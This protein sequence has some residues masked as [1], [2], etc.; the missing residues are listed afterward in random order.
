MKATKFL[1][2]IAAIT[3]AIVLLPC[4]GSSAY[5]DDP[6]IVE[7]LDGTATP[8]VRSI[9]VPYELPK[10][11][12]IKLLSTDPVF[13][14]GG[15]SYHSDAAWHYKKSDDTWAIMPGDQQ[16]LEGAYRYH[17]C[18]MCP[19]ENYAFA[20]TATLIIDDETWTMI[21]KEKL[22]TGIEYALFAS[23]EINLPDEQLD[24]PGPIKKTGDTLHDY[25]ISWTPVDK[26]KGYEITV[27]NT[28]QGFAPKETTFEVGASTNSY[29]LKDVFKSLSIRTGHNTFI[30]TVKALAPAGY[31]DSE[32]AS[33]STAEGSQ[34]AFMVE[35][36]LNLKVDATAGTASWDPYPFEEAKYFYYRLV[37]GTP[38]GKQIVDGYYDS[39][40]TTC[41]IESNIEYFHGEAGKYYLYVI[42]MDRMKSN[43]GWELTEPD[44]VEYNY[45][46]KVKTI[47][48][49]GV[50]QPMEGDLAQAYIGDYSV[51]EANLSLPD[52]GS[53][54]AYWR[55]HVSGSWVAM[56]PTDK[57]EASG[58][59]RISIPVRCEAG[60][61]FATD[62]TVSVNGK[63]V[64]AKIEVINDTTVRIECP[65]DVIAL[66]D[67]TYVVTAG[68]LNVRSDA[69]TAGA[70]V[71]GLSYGDVVQAVG[72]SGGWTMIDFEGQTAWVN[73]SYLALCPSA[74]Q[75]GAPFEDGPV[76]YTV[77]AGAMNVR[78]TPETPTD[79]GNRI[80]G[81]SA[82]REILATGSF[83]DD[84]GREWVT[85]DYYDSSYPE[86]G[87]RLGYVMF[88]RPNS[89][90]SSGTTYYFNNSDLP[91]TKSSG[92][93]DAASDE[94][95][96]DTGKFPK[97]S[98]EP[99]KAAISTGNTASLTD[100]NFENK[101]DGYLLTT[102][103]PDDAKNFASLT[104]DKVILPAAL[105][106]MEVAE[107]T[108]NT[109][110]SITLRLGPMNPVTVAFETNGGPEV[111]SQTVSSGGTVSK[112]E[113]PVRTGYVF[114]GWFD[115]AACNTSHNFGVP[116]T[117]SITVYAKWTEIVYTF[118]KGADGTWT[119]GSS[120]GFD[121]TVNRSI[122][123]DKTFSLFESIEVDGV[124]IAASNYTAASGSLEASL[125]AAF[126]ET[127]SAGEHAVKVNFSDS[128]A[129]TTLTIAEAASKDDSGAGS[130]DT[131]SSTSGTGAKTGDESPAGLLVGLALAAFI[132]FACA[133]YRRRIVG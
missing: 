70:H 84:L 50:K 104:K 40:I 51:E 125:N 16:F 12:D 49:N 27:K 109:D 114:G 77:T 17:V 116:V 4:F 103:F 75:L 63:T 71:G 93:E 57:F 44:Y 108:L 26:A 37:Y 45:T 30:I 36:H 9:A 95:V 69:S 131:S 65:M 81:L 85:M 90:S 48:V 101:D 80:G 110:G 100:E 99:L 133:A 15:L 10:A 119:K 73:A 112:P 78:S 79:D 25:G 98:F 83:T 117:E 64:A 124:V 127:L 107:L 14:A 46:P 7:S 72:Q 94:L 22:S 97:V 47:S 60:Y 23:P 53:G 6:V 66:S 38:D 115:D 111:A 55:R 31:K 67:S 126:L 59:Y 56:V 89:A 8:T 20:D 52:P 29:D 11:P 1:G 18:V 24:S 128:S 19:D 82:G 87:H 33:S 54:S 130:G 129:E 76:K 113:D 34:W 86:N 92:K 68:A 132:V 121:L 35:K 2:M 118:S 43:D 74:E 62:A 32:P 91:P 41:Y 28:T 96:I 58:E 123:D 120:S 61:T 106:G 102:V 42:A 13:E 21:K 88:S 3:M 39:S 105:A 122:E 5:A